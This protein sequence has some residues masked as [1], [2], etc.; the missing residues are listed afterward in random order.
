MDKQTT[1][2]ELSHLHEAQWKA[3]E[4]T[5]KYRYVLYGGSMGSGKSYWLRW[6]MVWWLLKLAAETKLPG[7][8]AGLF[9]EDYGSL[10]DRHISKIKTEFPQGLGTYNEQRHEFQL[11]P[12]LGGGIIAFRNLDDPTKYLSSEFAI[13]GV[14]ELIKEPKSTFD[15]LRTRL[16]WTGIPK[17]RFMAAT[18]PGEGWVK[19]YWVEKNFPPEE[20]EVSEFFY[21]KALP[22]DNPALPKEYF[23]QLSALPDVEKRAFL[24]GD[25][26][27]FERAMDDEGYYPLLSSSELANAFIDE[28]IHA[29]DSVISIDPAAGGDNSSIV[30]KSATCI[31]ILFNQKTKDIMS[32]VPLTIGYSKSY[33]NLKMILQDK[34]GVGEGLLARLK[35]LKRD[36]GVPVKGVAFSES[37]ADKKMFDNKKS[38]LYWD[39]RDWILRGGKLVRDDGW[40]EFLTVKFK[41]TS[42]GKI[43]IMPKDEMRRRGL[44]S[45]NC[46]D[47]AVVAMGAPKHFYIPSQRPFYDRSEQIWRG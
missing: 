8:R 26:S 5:E 38:E 33:G 6:V 3:L 12:H 11:H 18:N 41:R 31:Q 16:R 45:P 2:S 32:L 17:T 27:A 4:A 37:P 10:N 15:I 14:D 29:G 39:L 22:S 43:K 42:D 36:L 46:V 40:N 28:P 24:E 25:W 23:D 13:I 1:F 35:E 19:Q 34:T 21:V 30:V 44:K 20:S 7:I 9:C 47:A